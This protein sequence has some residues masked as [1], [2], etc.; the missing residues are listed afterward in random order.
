[1]DLYFLA[2]RRNRLWLSNTICSSQERVGNGSHSLGV[3]FFLFEEQL[4][5]SISWSREMKK[6]FR[7]MTH[8]MW[9]TTMAHHPDIG[10]FGR[11]YHID[12]SR[13]YVDCKVSGVDPS[14]LLLATHSSQCQVWPFGYIPVR[15]LGCKRHELFVHV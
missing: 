10:G 8:V 11:V 7:G 3:S 9:Q 13:I 12:L 5:S 4:T 14:D 15:N 6:Q 2:G 1:M